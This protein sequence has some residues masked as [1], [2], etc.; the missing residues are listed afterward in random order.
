[1]GAGFGVHAATGVPD[2]KFNPGIA[3]LLLLA[4]WL[5]AVPGNERHPAAVGHGIARVEDQIQNDLLNLCWI[6]P[7]QA[8]IIRQFGNEF[9]VF[10]IP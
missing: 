8:K 2:S 6:H 1:M 5:I 4:R 3:G 9:D 7:Y 10:A